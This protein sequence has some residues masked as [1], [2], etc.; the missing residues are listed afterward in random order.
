MARSICWKLRRCLLTPEPSRSIAPSGLN[1]PRTICIPDNTPT[2][3]TV[4]EDVYWMQIPKSTADEERRLALL[5]R[6][7]QAISKISKMSHYYWTYTVQRSDPRSHCTYVDIDLL[8]H[9]LHH[10]LKWILL[11]SCK[12]KQFRLN[13]IGG[14]GVDIDRQRKHDISVRRWNGFV[15]ISGRDKPGGT[16]TGDFQD[17]P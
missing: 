3:R 12:V 17:Q 15:T 8:F 5:G 13:W 4:N 1:Q 16:R 10:K 9:Y 14:I 2:R 7:W 11:K 6:I